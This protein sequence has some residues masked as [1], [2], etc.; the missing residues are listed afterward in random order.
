MPE[1]TCAICDNRK[2]KTLSQFKFHESS[3]SHL[4]KS[5]RKV[6]PEV[7]P[8]RAYTFSAWLNSGIVSRYIFL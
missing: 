1:F 8:K 7:K 4:A 2:F 3:K 6:E 5:Q